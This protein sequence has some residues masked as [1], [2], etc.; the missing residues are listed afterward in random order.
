MALDPRVAAALSGTQEISTRCI[1]AKFSGISVFLPRFH[2]CSFEGNA[3]LTTVMVEIWLYALY[4]LVVFALLKRKDDRVFWSWLIALW[5]IGAIYVSGRPHL[6]SWWHNGS[7]L[8]FALYWWLGA[9]FIDPGFCASVRKWRW[10]AALT[11]L[12]LTLCLL[13]KVPDWPLLVEARKILFSILIGSL[14]AEIDS[15]RLRIGGLATGIGRAGY[16]LYAFHAPLLVYLLLSGLHWVLVA[17]LTVSISL[18]IYATFEGP[19]V[20]L[21]KRLSQPGLP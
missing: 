15:M 17:T 2:E 7:L 8:G 16:S 3:P 6:L 18:L 13:F 9:K 12:A 11:W 1:G 4:A 19:L 10:L 21:G 5:T 20:R 14:I